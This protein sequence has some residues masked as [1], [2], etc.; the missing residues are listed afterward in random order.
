MISRS[1]TA[2]LHE[3]R[4]REYFQVEKLLL[5][6]RQREL[7]M[8]SKLDEI[9]TTQKKLEKK[10]TTDVAEHQTH[11][12]PV[13]K[14]IFGAS[15]GHGCS[16]DITVDTEDV[17]TAG[18]SKTLS[19]WDSKKQST[20]TSKAA[21]SGKSSAPAAIEIEIHRRPVRTRVSAA[22]CDVENVYPPKNYMG[23]TPSKQPMS[24][25]NELATMK[26]VDAAK[27]RRRSERIK[28]TYKI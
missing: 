2:A 24:S 8:E 23:V 21:S 14:N 19:T 18:D 16:T 7:A 3:Q 4:E 1:Q 13:S 25:R 28:S 11:L 17:S 27:S 5:E 20:A 9:T 15:N 6:Q 22:A 12:Q 26:H 10:L